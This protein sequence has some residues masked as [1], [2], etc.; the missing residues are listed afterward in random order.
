MCGAELYQDTL[1][2]IELFDNFILM[3]RYHIIT[4]EHICVRM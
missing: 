1:G 3:K 4:Y 2:P